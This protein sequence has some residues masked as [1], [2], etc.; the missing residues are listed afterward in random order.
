M[1][2]TKPAP[3]VVP[4]IAIAYKDTMSPRTI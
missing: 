4:N 2:T 3:Y 1:D